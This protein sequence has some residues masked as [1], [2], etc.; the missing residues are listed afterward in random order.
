M[1]HVPTF[2]DAGNYMYWFLLN[3][4]YPKL[5]FQPW[6]APG[7]TVSGLQNLTAPLFDAWERLGISVSP[8]Y[9]EHD[10]FLGA[11]NAAFPQEAV[12]SNISKA[13]SRLVPR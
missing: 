5:I 10:G 1:L 8:D 11:Y 6:F 12:A 13:A 3:V 9:Y 4:G 2:L 7:M